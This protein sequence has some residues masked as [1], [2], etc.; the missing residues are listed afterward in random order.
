[1][2]ANNLF[3]YIPR[4][5]VLIVSMLMATMNAVDVKT[6]EKTKPSQALSN[7]QYLFNK[8]S[9]KDMLFS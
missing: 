7:S 8:F 3:S 2:K 6:I 5:L 9:K 1:M 4:I